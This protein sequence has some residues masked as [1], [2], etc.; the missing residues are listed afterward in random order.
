M[1]HTFILIPSLSAAK[2]AYV[3]VGRQILAVQAGDGGVCQGDGVR[4]LY[5]RSW[6]KIEGPKNE[7]HR[8]SRV[9]RSP[10]VR[11]QGNGPLTRSQE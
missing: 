4:L 1:C 11:L 8:R 7:D 2:D 9:T 6:D 10:E 3:N 5:Y